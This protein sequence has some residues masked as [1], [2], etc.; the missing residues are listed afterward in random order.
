[1][2]GGPTAPEVYKETTATP[3][4]ARP[5]QFRHQT[6]VVDAAHGFSSPPG[7][8]QA[9]SQYPPSAF[10][11]GVVDEAEEGVW[12]Y[13]F[14]LDHKF[15]DSLVLKKR[16][17]F[18]SPANAAHRNSSSRG[19]GNPPSQDHPGGYLIGRHPECGE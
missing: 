11:A 9:F 8:T 10:A 18:A 4:A 15:G 16:D 6:P 19:R 14:P 2:H 17:S 1:M 5:S 3:P 13:L 12:G 7:D